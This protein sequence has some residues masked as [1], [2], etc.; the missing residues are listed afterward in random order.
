VRAK[1]VA[2]SLLFVAVAGLS[3]LLPAWLEI[4][5]VSASPGQPGPYGRRLNYGYF[6]DREED[7]GTVVIPGGEHANNINQLVADM[8]GHFASGS[9]Q[10]H[11]GASFIMNTMMQRNAAG[12]LNLSPAEI[13]DWESRVRSPDIYI[14]FSENFSFCIN[15]YWQDGNQDDAFYNRNGGS[16]CWN[17]SDIVDG[18]RVG[19]SIVFHDRAT[20]APLYAIRRAC[21]NPVGNPGMR[22]IPQPN[23]NMSAS[24]VARVNGNVSGTAEAGDAVSFTYR[25][26]NGGP[27]TAQ[28]VTCQTF[29]HDYTGYRVPPAGV[30]AGSSPGP[31]MNCSGDIAPGAFR[32]IVENI[33]AAANTTV[34]RFLIVSPQNRSG[35]SVPVQA[36]VTVYSKPYVKV[37]GGDVEAGASFVPCGAAL[38]ANRGSLQAFNRGAAQGYAGSGAEGV[39]MAYRAITEFVSADMR[40]AAPRVPI[41]L[42][43]ANNNPAGAPYGGN[44]GA[45]SCITDY[46]RL[47]TSLGAVINNPGAGSFPVGA[48][49]LGAGAKEDIFVDGDAI[50]TGNIVYTG[51]WT[52]NLTTNTIPSFRLIVRNGNIYIRDTVTQL[53]GLYVAIPRADGS[54]GQIYTCSLVAA[55]PNE[56]QVASG[57]KLQLRVNGAFISQGVKLLR[58]PNSLNNATASEASAGSR[59]GEIFTY[60]PEVWLAIPQFRFPGSADYDSMASLPPVL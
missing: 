19:P 40:G 30:D 5:H 60:V 55:P 53:D 50:I 37:Y 22:G 21:G 18:V 32:E 59:A 33:T 42:T 6:K 28:G 9:A 48:R 27:G 2:L 51:S 52:L 14:N 34:C 36:C 20:G 8:R 15:T 29:R 58:T 13:D 11:I 47:S 31:G 54:K 17:P 4:Q 16:S 39:A 49:N 56:Q 26:T 3:V 25:A 1:R 44:F 57:C 12:N 45:G 10:R 41:G 24:L 35:G 43:F 23:F 46:W 7:W 38:P